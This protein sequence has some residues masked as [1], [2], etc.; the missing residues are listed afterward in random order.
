MARIR[1]G[2][3]LVELLVVIAIIGVLMSLLLPAVQTARESTRRTSCSN[4]FKQLG[5][6][7]LNYE[8]ARKCLPTGADAKVWDTAPT[9]PQTFFRWSTFAQL[10]PYLEETAAR[11]ALDLSVPLYTNVAGVVSA[12]NRTGVALKISL[13]L[14]PTD[15]GEAVDAGFGPL[16]YAACTGDGTDGGSPFQTNGLFYINSRT[17][18][19]DISDGLS[20]TVA[21]SESILGTG[22]ESMTANLNQVDKQTVYAYV[23]G[24]PLTDASCNSAVNFNWTNRRGF[25]WVNGEYRCGLFNNYLAPDSERID[26]IASVLSTSDP[27]QIYAGY[28]WRG[29]RSRHSGGV[30]IL[31]ADGSV[32]FVPDGVNQHIWQAISTRAGGEA[33]V[34]AD[35]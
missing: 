29:A 28:G 23:F 20:K 22:N 33:V 19:R 14:C 15:A 8:S 6:A 30:N 7:L 34:D 4:N 25:A 2:F 16:N 12:Q 31:L 5:V 9:L 11:N 21:M 18:L 32:H 1:R 17:R 24:T 10:T 35:P 27:A 3:T 13:F 26:C